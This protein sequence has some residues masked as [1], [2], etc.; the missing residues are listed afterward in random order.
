MRFGKQ[1]SWRITLLLGFEK[2]N[3][4]Y[5]RPLSYRLKSLFQ[6]FLFLLHVLYNLQNIIF[7]NLDLREK[8]REKEKR[9][10]RVFWL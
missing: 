3:K 8:K 10:N 5:C 1:N 6:S 2:V 4:L 7:I 9:E